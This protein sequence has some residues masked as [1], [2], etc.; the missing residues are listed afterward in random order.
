MACGC[1][2]DDGVGE[3][4]GGGDAGTVDARV[5]DG[6]P[7]TGWRELAPLPGGPRQE[8]AVVAVGTKVYVMGGFDEGGESNAVEIYETTSD[9]WSDG[10]DLPMALHHA[11]AAVV[12]TRVVVVGGMAD[13]FN[14]VGDVF[15][16][17]AAGSGGWETGASMPS[18]SERGAGAVGAIGPYVYVA[19]GLADGSVTAFSR[20]HV[21]DEAWEPLPDL[22]EPRNHIVGAAVGEH[23]Y[24]VGGRDVGTDG[25][26]PDVWRWDGLEWTARAPMTTARGGAAG[27]VLEGR[28]F[29]LGGEGAPTA[30][31]VFDE[32][33]SYDPEAD[34]W[35]SHT[36]MLTPRHG[37]GAAAVGSSIYVPGGATVE[38]FGWTEVHEAF[39]P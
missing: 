13:G 4:G 35:A 39:A 20:Y 32:V 5:E 16:W 29:V 26:Q 3:D 12:G 28:I 30:S 1:G 23:F 34:T 31:G 21:M 36:P 17:D 11:N 22:P 24:A 38:G 10:P 14:A 15:V 27:A 2:D 9:T 7:M 37:T 19:G 6:S 18:G 8:T 33:E 25:V